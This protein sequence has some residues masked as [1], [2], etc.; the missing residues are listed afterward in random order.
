MFKVLLINPNKW[1]RGITHIWIASHSS[2][3]KKKNIK[4]ELFD[5]TFYKNWTDNEVEFAT[6]TGMFKKSS[7]LDLVKFKKNDVKQDLQ[8][9]FTDQN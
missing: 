1:G 7:Y 3:L 9:I 2:I 5:A 8:K 4:V 6:S